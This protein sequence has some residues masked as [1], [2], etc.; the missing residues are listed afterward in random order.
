MNDKRL[1]LR[2][3]RTMVKE[4]LLSA[5]DTRFIQLPKGPSVC[6]Y[7]TDQG[8]PVCAIGHVFSRIGIGLGD[9][10]ALKLTVGAMN[11]ARFEVIEPIW[12]KK[13]TPSASQ[14]LNEIQRAQDNGIPWRD[15]YERFF[16]EEEDDEATSA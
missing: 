2:E 3:A 1:G 5:P 7:F 4:I 8:E 12:D 10:L 9:L 16:G 13:I 6:K 11:T 14:F 15:V